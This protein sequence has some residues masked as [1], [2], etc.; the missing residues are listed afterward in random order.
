MFSI[1]TKGLTCP[2]VEVASHC[3]LSGYQWSSM[4]GSLQ[5]CRVSP[6]PVILSCGV[7]RPGPLASV[8]DISEE[9]SSSR[10]MHRLAEASAASQSLVLRLL[11]PSWLLSPRAIPINP[12]R[13]TLRVRVG[14]QGTLMYDYYYY[15]N[16]HLN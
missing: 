9:P 10:V 11:S 13:A 7:Q 16:C 5:G 1:K 6:H 3:Q 8:Q 4:E 12:M 2:G 14:L 15:F